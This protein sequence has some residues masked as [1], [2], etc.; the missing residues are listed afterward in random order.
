[1]AAATKADVVSPIGTTVSVV[2]GYPATFDDAGYGALTYQKVGLVENVGLPESTGTVET[3]NDLETGEIIKVITF[4]DGGQFTFDTV[5]KPDTDGQSVMVDYHNGANAR[6]PIS[7][8]V[9]HS[10]GDIR[11]M[12]GKVSTYSPNLDALNRAS[13]TVEIDGKT[14]YKVAP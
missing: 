9:A 13:F 4:I 3:F 8:E 11:Y 7:I 12:S 10:N 2:G 5:D 14:I 6:Q 1:M